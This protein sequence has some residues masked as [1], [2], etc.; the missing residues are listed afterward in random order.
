[1]KWAVFFLFVFGLSAAE[2]PI[3]ISLGARCGTATSLSDL[4]YRKKAYP[5][6]WLVTPFDGLCQALE[7]DFAHFLSGCHREDQGIIDFYGFQFY[8][9]FPKEGPF[10]DAM[11]AVMKKY[12]RR[13]KRFQEVCL[14]ANK[15]IFIRAEEVSQQKAIILRDLLIRKY[16]ALDFILIAITSEECTEEPWNLY[17]IRNLRAS[18]HQRSYIRRFILE[19]LRETN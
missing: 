15:V 10:E 3:F 9:D 2:E 11:S 5:L 19:L 8:H 7:D 16:P 13:I 14:G 12:Q 6:D 4:R 18:W 1:M 17:R